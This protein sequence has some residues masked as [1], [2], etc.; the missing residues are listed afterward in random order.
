MNPNEG[1]ICIPE[2]ESK[3]IE[4]EDEGVAD[5][6]HRFTFILVLGLKAKWVWRLYQEWQSLDYRPCWG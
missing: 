5:K 6:S 4:K 3:Q 2:P 1:L